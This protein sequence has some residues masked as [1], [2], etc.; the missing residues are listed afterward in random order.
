MQ[1]NSQ[2]VRR[3]A[4]TRAAGY[5]NV[6]ARLCTDHHPAVCLSLHFILLY[7]CLV[8]L[9]LLGQPA[10]CEDLAGQFGEVVTSDGIDMNSFMMRVFDT[11]RQ[12]AAENQTTAPD[13]DNNAT[14]A[15][16]AAV[17]VAAAPVS[18][19]P[20]GSSSL[21]SPSIAHVK[22]ATAASRKRADR[23]DN[24]NPEV[25][26]NAPPSKIIKL[27]AKSSLPT[28]AASVDAA[29]Q[30]AAPSAASA[31]FGQPAPP[32]KLVRLTGNE[33]ARKARFG[34][35]VPS[36]SAAS[37]SSSMDVDISQPTIPV[38][39][40]PTP[41]VGSLPSSANSIRRL[42]KPG[43]VLRTWEDEERERKEKEE[44]DRIEREER[45]KQLTAASEAAAAKKRI[46]C[47]HWP[48]CM[49]GNRCDYHHPT[50]LCT[51]F[52]ACKFGDACLYIHP[53]V[54]CRFGVLCTNA[55]CG[56]SHPPGR[57]L[58]A[59]PAHAAASA[60]ASPPAPNSVP[61]PCKFGVNCARGDCFFTHPPTRAM[62]LAGK[63][64]PR[65]SPAQTVCR[66]DPR[67][68]NPTCPFMHPSKNTSATAAATDAAAPET[69]A[70]TTTEEA[71]TSE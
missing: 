35:A 48:Q 22:A 24:I 16:H 57:R 6:P 4:Y 47:T 66:F 34:G 63:V 2:S 45:Q 9:M 27:G 36:T 65:A 62:P 3:Q 30:P 71:A 29:G 54:P 8:L 14:A 61:T 44:K 39:V 37:S 19:S 60:A 33:E 15:A 49:A 5:R 17:G 13:T 43:E 69:T 26:A 10:S 59:P 51:S 7:L 40:A 12:A 53:V 56:F 21:A 42:R 50:E 31:T 55:Q 70:P 67:C 20:V 52:P 38:R 25:A 32:K 64:A 18:V 68:L 23:S 11:V 46:R 41:S 28:A 58:R 1:S